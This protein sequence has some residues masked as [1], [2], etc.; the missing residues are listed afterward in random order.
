MLR[1]LSVNE[2]DASFHVPQNGKQCNFPSNKCIYSP[3][4]KL[5]YEFTAF[6]LSKFTQANSN[7]L[8]ES[9]TSPPNWWGYKNKQSF[10]SLISLQKT[11]RHKFQNPLVLFVIPKIVKKKKTPNGRP[12]TISDFFLLLWF[13]TT[14]RHSRPPLEFT[15][16]WNFEMCQI[17]CPHA[18]ISANRELDVK[19]ACRGQQGSWS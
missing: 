6:A 5:T 17:H 14:K 18:E 4:W 3:K 11:A 1:F 9:V 12:V 10:L 7:Q 13:M 16:R 15:N 2:W 8:F 19:A